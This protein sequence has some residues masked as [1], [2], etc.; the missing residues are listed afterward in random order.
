MV[1]LALDVG[2][3]TGWALSSGE[4]G[5]TSFSHCGD[6]GARVHAF[7]GWLADMLAE[8]QPARLVMERP[9]GRAGFTSDLPLILCGVAHGVAHAHEVPRSEVTASQVKK[10]VTGKGNAK[11]RAVIVGVEALGWA[12]SSDHAADAAAVIETWRAQ[13]IAAEG[14]MGRAA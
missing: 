3:T 10:A 13:R 4:C 12:P 14:P 5:E 2:L 7:H 1:V 11:K 8:H 9:F 6:L